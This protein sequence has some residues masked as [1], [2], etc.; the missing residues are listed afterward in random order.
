VCTTNLGG[1]VLQISQMVAFR[2]LLNDV[3]NVNLQTHSGR[4]IGSD[5]YQAKPS[6]FTKSWCTVVTY[7]YHPD[8]PTTFPN[9]FSKLSLNISISRVTISPRKQEQ[10]ARRG[11]GGLKFLDQR[12]TGVRN[13]LIILVRASSHPKKQVTANLP[14]ARLPVLGSSLYLD[15]SHA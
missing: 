8:S 4:T 14:L 9:Y 6:S 5:L 15:V 13:S 2:A 7:P 11:H 10:R 3:T 1:V 12:P